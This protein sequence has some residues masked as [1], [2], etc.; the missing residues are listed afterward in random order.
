MPRI[1]EEPTTTPSGEEWRNET[2]TTHPAFAQIGAYRVSGGNTALYGSDFK[3]NAYMTIV[4]SRSELNRSLNRDW[5]HG[6][7]EI[8]EIA[9]SEAQWATFVSSPGMGS[10]VP[11]TLQHLMGEQVPGLPDPA[12][13]SDQFSDEMKKKLEGSAQSVR[14]AIASIDAL[15]LPKGKTTTLRGALSS[16]LT[17][18][19]S[20]LPFVAS[21][22]EEHM[23]DTVEKAKQEV[24]GYMTSVLTRAG[25]ESLIGPDKLPLQIE[26]H[27]PDDANPQ[28]PS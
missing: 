12:S 19:N 13:R 23:E 2:K 24:H 14:D 27:R 5:H 15:G 3:H 17:Q 4:I 1:I 22:F 26:A 21:Q 20:N 9:L 6:R 16:L 11:C 10:G 8:I 25:L 7:K 18:L 28:S